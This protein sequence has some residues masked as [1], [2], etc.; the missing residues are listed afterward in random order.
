MLHESLFQAGVNIKFV[1]RQNVQ[2]LL[3]ALQS[4]ASGSKTDDKLC[5]HTYTVSIR[6]PGQLHDVLEV[7]MDPEAT[8]ASSRSESDSESEEK[9]EKPSSSL[10]LVCFEIF[11]VHVIFVKSIQGIYCLCVYPT[12]QSQ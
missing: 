10:S 6:K 8:F 3:T 2:D 7:V 9:G 1:C 4:D 11:G 5:G 12:Q